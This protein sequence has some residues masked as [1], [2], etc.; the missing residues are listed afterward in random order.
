MFIFLPLIDGMVITGEI[1]ST[2]A[3][4]KASDDSSNLRRSIERMLTAL[5][6]VPGDGTNHFEVSRG[7]HMYVHWITSDNPHPST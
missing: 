2:D 6:S 3:R 1:H 4:A 7:G 5:L